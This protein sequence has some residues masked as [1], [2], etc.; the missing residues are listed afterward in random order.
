[1]RPVTRRGRR[2]GQGLTDRGG[3]TRRPVAVAG[4]N[5]QA[6]LAGRPGYAH[7]VAQ[8]YDDP[9][10][11]RADRSRRISQVTRRDIF[12]HLRTEGRPWWGRM[13]EIGFLD[14]LYDLEALPSTDRRFAT[15]DRDIR[16]HRVD[17]VGHLSGHTGSSPRAST[18]AG[19]S[20]GTTAG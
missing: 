2:G 9:F 7:F 14:R 11:E 6:E 20:A 10:G 19:V 18:A 5:V 13:T 4:R 15:A 12:D 3:L 17:H 8:L 1:V 16:Q